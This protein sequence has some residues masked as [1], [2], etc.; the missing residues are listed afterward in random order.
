MRGPPGQRARGRAKLC[1]PEGAD[2]AYLAHLIERR[3]QRSPLPRKACLHRDV[4]LLGPDHVRANWEL[5]RPLAF[6]AKR[7]NRRNYRHTHQLRW[8]AISFSISIA[9]FAVASDRGGLGSAGPAAGF[10]PAATTAPG[11]GPS[12][13]DI[14]ATVKATISAHNRNAIA[15][16]ARAAGRIHHAPRQ[17][18]NLG[19]TLCKAYT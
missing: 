18:R 13:G 9:P 19:G 6:S 11:A 7:G 10:I 2:D 5:L 4:E 17:P 14:I 15:L 16:E 8:S 3:P 12:A 1:G